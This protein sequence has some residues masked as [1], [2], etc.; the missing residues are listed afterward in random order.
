M[1]RTKKSQSFKEQ[2]TYEEIHF[3]VSA[4]KKG[5]LSD[6]RTLKTISDI[7]DQRHLNLVA[8]NQGQTYSLVYRYCVKNDIDFISKDLDL[9]KNPNCLDEILGLYQ[10]KI[11]SEQY[12]EY[13]HIAYLTNFNDCKTL[14]AIAKR[15]AYKGVK[16]EI[17]KVF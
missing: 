17:R 12:I 16:T 3:I 4:T 1:A 7:N 8:S 2:K 5:F 9:R 10:P 11:A 13:P 6:T 15:L 14:N